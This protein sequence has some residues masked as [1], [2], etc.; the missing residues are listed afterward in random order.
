MKIKTYYELCVLNKSRTDPVIGTGLIHLVIEF[1]VKWGQSFEE[2]AANHDNYHGHVQEPG[3]EDADG[4]DGGRQVLFV[5]VVQDGHQAR[6]D[7]VAWVYLQPEEEVVRLLVGPDYFDN[8]ACECDLTDDY[9]IPNTVK[10][11]EASL[12][13]DITFL[14]LLVEIHLE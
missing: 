1:W 8:Y 4:E 14:L 7:A 13:V 12:V 6:V 2:I 5:R 10:E 3:E 9:A 11:V